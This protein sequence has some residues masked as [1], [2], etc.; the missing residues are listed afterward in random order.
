[1][2]SSLQQKTKQLLTEYCNDGT[3]HSLNITFAELLK[4]VWNRII[5]HEHKEEIIKI[6][7]EEMENA[8][9]KCFTGRIS[10]LVNVL[11]GYYDDINIKISDNA[12]IGTIISIIKQQYTG[13]N[14]VELKIIIK[15]E[16]KE[17]NINEKLIEE[18][19]EHIDI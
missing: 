9:C 10:R 3:I 7:D 11:N 17:R 1:M 19:I 2:H 12:Q 18:W 16:L 8:E 13:N 14:I 6:L 15:K 5:K 4:F